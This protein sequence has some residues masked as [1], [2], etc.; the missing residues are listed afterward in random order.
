MLIL[1]FLFV[2]VRIIFFLISPIIKKT[3]LVKVYNPFFFVRE[4][5]KYI[6]IHLG[7]ARDLLM[8]KTFSRRKTLI[9]LV[10]GLLKLIDE[11]ESGRIDINKIIQGNPYFFKP[12]NFQ[13][14]GFQS[15]E[16]YFSEKIRFYLNYFELSFL[17]SFVSKKIVLVKVDKLKIVHT[18]AGTLLA[19]KDK[20]LSIYHRL[21]KE[22]EIISD[23]NNTD[24]QLISK[25]AV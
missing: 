7:F 6:E 3:L 16:L 15:R 24:Y 17:K 22:N 19:N 1:L 2:G 20:I 11:I 9:Y 4:K 8:S 21:R 12:A 25:T 14:F 10:S 18:T 13:N 5:R 23:C